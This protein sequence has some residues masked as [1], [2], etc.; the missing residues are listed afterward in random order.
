MLA[1]LSLIHSNTKIQTKMKQE[2]KGNVTVFICGLCGHSCF[3]PHSL[4][5]LPGYL[6]T[7]VLLLQTMNKTEIAGQVLETW[8]LML[9][10]T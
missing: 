3:K 2:R 6:A 1:T 8:T 5:W 9:D 7:A 4:T 10:E